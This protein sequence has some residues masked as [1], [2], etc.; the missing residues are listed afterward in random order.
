MYELSDEEYER[1]EGIVE[2]LDSVLEQAEGDGDVP[3]LVMRRDIDEF[4]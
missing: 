1:W 4:G 2:R 3:S